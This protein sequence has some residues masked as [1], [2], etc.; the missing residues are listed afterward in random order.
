MQTRFIKI[1]IF[2]IVFFWANLFVYG[3]PQ[4]DVPQPE[5]KPVY[6]P[7]NAH[8]YKSEEI[9][10]KLKN[11]E[12]RT[13]LAAT[14]KEKLTRI[15]SDSLDRL[16][17]IQ[18]LAVLKTDYETKIN[19]APDEK[20]K[21]QG[22]L[23][24][25]LKT[26][27]GY[28]DDLTLDQ[29][30]QKLA[31][32]QVE[33]SVAQ[34]EATALVNEPQRRANRRT[35]IP[36]EITAVND[37][38]I[39]KTEKVTDSV[40]A[41]AI[42]E[43]K[44]AENTLKFLTEDALKAK[45]KTLEL[46]LEMYNARGELLPLRKEYY[47]KKQQL[48]SK[49]VKAWEEHVNTRR[50]L[51]AEAA[52]QQA[53]DVISEVASIP[54]LDTLSK[55]NFEIA[56][57]QSEIAIKIEAA[58]EFQKKIEAELKGLK[59]E[60]ERIQKMVNEVGLSPAIGYLLHTK[61]LNLGDIKEYQ[62]R[63]KDR[64]DQMSLAQFELLDYDEK[65]SNLK[66]LADKAED[67]VNSSSV[68]GRFNRE[69][70]IDKAEEL[71]Q[72]KRANLETLVGYY[73]NYTNTLAAIDVAERNY[74][75]LFLE[76]ENFINEH[77]LWVKNTQ[78][79]SFNSL[80]QIGPE[81]RQIFSYD[82][83][84]E[85]ADACLAGVGQNK[86]KSV[87]LWLFLFLSLVIR[88]GSRKHLRVLAEDV[89]VPQRDKY[90]Y[91]LRAVLITFFYSM[92][93]PIL[94]YI[95]GWMINRGADAFP[96]AH[97]LASAFIS[98]ALYDLVMMPLR[99][100][101][102]DNGLAGAHF[103]VSPKNCRF[104]FR[105]SSWFV[106][107]L[108]PLLVFLYLQHN[109]EGADWKYQFSRLIFIV[110]M[111]LFSLYLAILFNPKMGVLSEFS[112]ASE[113]K[114]VFRIGNLVYLA[115]ISIP[116]CLAVMA[117][118]GYFYAAWQLEVRMFISF[119]AGLLFMLV[120]ALVFRRV[121]IARLKIIDKHKEADRSASKTD[122]KDVDDISEEEVEDYCDQIM[123]FVRL[124]LSFAF[125]ISLLV[126]FKDV[127]P[128]LAVLE[129]VDLWQITTDNNGLEWVTL[130][131]LLKSMTILI[132]TI[133]MAR[134]IT[135]LINIAL[136]KSISSK[137][138]TR[139]AILAIIRYAIAIIGVIWSC[140]ELGIGWGKVQWM[141]AA[142]TVGLGFGLQ[143]IF[144]N[145]ISG[146]I[147]LFEQPMRV[148]DVVTV[149]DV[150]GKVTHINTR[151]TTIN[152]WD[153]RELIL[154]NKEFITG[155]LINWTLSD[156]LNRIS[157]QVGVAYGSDIEKVERTLLRIAR[158]RKGVVWKPT[159][160]VVFKGFGDS[161][162]D[163]ELRVFI[164]D[165]DDYLDIWHGINCAIDAEFRKENI[166]IAFP[167]RDLHLRSI[168]GEPLSIRIDNLEK[169]VIKEQELPFVQ[170]P[171]STE[172]NENG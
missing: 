170:E 7:F 69:E 23:E 106:F 63:L 66:D 17:E 98:I 16:S 124:V 169:S 102:I 95:V 131:S 172:N 108:Q 141:A 93:L 101:F 116:I 134:N 70:V 132:I 99:N 119:G 1:I 6:S 104:I 27:D 3:Q 48:L 171:P 158:F 87:F 68:H 149:G 118:R 72:T 100:V 8:G 4:V 45:A 38:L 12:L 10:A 25:D 15:Y 157:F 147:L 113:P 13:E 114:S 152:C 53:K 85:V 164:N 39:K 92:P 9:S 153:R 128:A 127:F 67:L 122:Q 44:Q 84:L 51:E 133:M 14:D 144:A 160:K 22:L 29:I 31:A 138:G 2:S 24:N 36:K 62:K 103:S 96:F 159:P 43:I 80:R 115:S 78:P 61:R 97:A 74:V 143:E 142:F 49:Q 163:F 130:A 136:L 58:G 40:P 77:I 146:I 123:R 56:Q 105:L 109:L 83:L 150:S 139:F 151:S 135:G 34:K 90:I 154:P 60:Y 32:L 145:F 71:L 162:L 137:E 165:M 94:F 33:L 30:E 167:Q 55:Q 11:L 81:I 47:T 65:R 112:N 52:S 107:V 75:A 120:Y 156:N 79:I 148:G 59:S 140:A 37:E 21:F 89:S 125:I 117:W 18:S 64:I 126:I 91:T 155:K 57:K 86:A 129:K 26:E 54:V 35:E 41:D 19:A 5:A 42:D 168:K 88:V 50:K 73:S 82:N 76:F 121:E 28:S 166:E 20:V 46:E 161:C 111:V 110:M